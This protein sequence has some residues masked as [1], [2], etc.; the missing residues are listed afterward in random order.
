MEVRKLNEILVESAEELAPRK[1]RQHR[2]AK[3]KVYSPEIKQ[4]IT[5]KKQ[6]FWQWKKAHRPNEEGDILV[7]NKKLTTKYL[8]KLCRMEAARVREHNPQEILE[9]KSS[10]TKLFYKLVNKQRG[11][12]RSCVNELSANG[13]VY[14]SDIDIL[15]GWR[16]HFET[17]ATPNTDCDYDRK[18]S[19]MVSEELPIIQDICKDCPA[20]IVS[21]EQVRKAIKSLN[22]GKAPDFYGVTAEHLLNGG[23]AAVKAATNLVNSMFQLGKVTEAL[24]VGALTPV[25]KKKGSCTEAKNYRGITVLPVITKVLETVLRDQIQPYVEQQQNSLQRGFTKHSSPMNCSLIM[26]ERH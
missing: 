26:E 6:A 5:D 23:E 10:D 11:S 12:K 16:D 1:P 13:Q 14:K 19:K 7:I 15:N 21:E 17:L 9:T 22:T 4:A 25:F 18:Y 3:L 24:K 2:K 8:R 20:T